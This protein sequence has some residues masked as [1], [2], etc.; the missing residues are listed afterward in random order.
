M[1]YDNSH[2]P[3]SRMIEVT[4]N[5]PTREGSRVVRVGRHVHDIRRHGVDKPC[6]LLK[7]PDNRR[8]ERRAVDLLGN[9]YVLPIGQY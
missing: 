4:Y 9:P 8:P 5:E 6:D 7:E 1:L 3:G 2:L